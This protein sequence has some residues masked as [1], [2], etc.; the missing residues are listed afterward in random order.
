MRQKKL[1][2]FVAPVV[3]LALLALAP[4]PARAQDAGAFRTPWGHPD[5]QG[6]WTNT[7]TTPMQRPEELAG[8]ERLSAEER[9]EL[10][11]EAIRNADRPPPPGSTGAYNDF[12]FERGVRTEQTAWV[13]DPPDGRLPPITAKERD[14]MAAMAVMRNAD[15]YPTTWEDVNIYE[16]CISRG[17]PGTMM[18]GFYNHNYLIL[19]TPDSVVIRAEMVHDTR[20]IP[21]DGRPHIDASI[22]QW[23][24][25]SRGYWDG[26]T[27]VVVTTNLTDKLWERRFSNT[28]YGTG[29]YMHL[30]ERFTRI[31]ENTI[32]YRFTVTDPTT[33]RRS[34]TAATPMETL[35]GPLFEYACHEGNYAMVNMLSGARARERDAAAA[36][37]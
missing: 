28:V 12:W 10:D 27:L 13:V 6:A 37:R 16:R 9:A 22:R 15:E 19:Q 29:E 32:D 18:P 1:R 3:G 7:T 5:L 34:W 35:D 21:L 2:R 24:G 30:E 11:A 23:L 17:M 20:V 4:I 31:D 33:F 25:D 8:R 26:D 14:R 36:G